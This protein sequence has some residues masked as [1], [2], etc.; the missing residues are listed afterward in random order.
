MLMVM[1]TVRKIEIFFIIHSAQVLVFPPSSSLLSFGSPCTHTHTHTNVH[2]R[3][4]PFIL[5]LPLGFLCLRQCAFL[6]HTHKSYKIEE[7]Q[8]QTQYNTNK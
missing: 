4:R 8:Q 3:Y 6:A 1:E 2:I 7:Q 5:R